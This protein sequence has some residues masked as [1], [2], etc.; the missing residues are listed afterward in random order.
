MTIHW[1]EQALKA[2]PKSR[3]EAKEKG[4]KWYF[5]DKPCAHGHLAPYFTSISRCTVCARL[6]SVAKFRED[7]AK[8]NAYS[9]A[10]Y[11]KHHPKRLLGLKLYKEN[12]PEMV[13][14]HNAS[15]DKERLRIESAL[16]RVMNPQKVKL[17]NA[18]GRI[19]HREKRIQQT[20]SWRGRNRSHLRQYSKQY[21][22][23]NRHRQQLYDASHYQKARR[24]MPFWADKEKILAIYEQRNSLNETHGPGKYH[25]DHIIPLMGKNGGVQNVSGLHVA[26]N[27]Q[28]ILA[29]DNLAKSNNYEV[30]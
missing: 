19:K 24:Q 22:E 20:R 15:R 17:S 21:R 26:E 2:L 9:N 16:Y 14:K 25:V 18:L 30:Y 8:A 23:K 12:N 27:L 1:S 11:Y 3:K 28:V 5:R 10:M 29:S 7:Q 6:S 4:S 13:K